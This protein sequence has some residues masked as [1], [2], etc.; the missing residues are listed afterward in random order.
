MESIDTIKW[1]VEFSVP[2]IS[3]IVGYFVGKR[4]RD[5]DFISDLQTSIDVLSEKNAKLI[6]Q[7]VELNDQVV[8]LKRENAEL[9]AEIASLNTKLD[10]VKTITR[11]QKND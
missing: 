9:K 6:K 8:S 10:G 1:I 2:I 5:N 3:A 4:K 7:V 11:V